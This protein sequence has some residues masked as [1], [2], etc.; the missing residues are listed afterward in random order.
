MASLDLGRDA[1][2]PDDLDGFVPSDEEDSATEKKVKSKK[3]TQKKEAAKAAGAAERTDTTFDSD[4]D[5]L[6]EELRQQRDQ[7][8]RDAEAALADAN[9]ADTADEI[10]PGIRDPFKNIP[11][12]QG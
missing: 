4:R 12:G 6:I 11:I 10:V 2:V 9:G 7:Q 1:G 3:P 8:A 5:A